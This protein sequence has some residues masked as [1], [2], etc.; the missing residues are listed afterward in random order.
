MW[1]RLQQRSHGAAASNIMATSPHWLEVLVCETASSFF[2]S[3]SSFQLQVLQFYQPTRLLQPSGPLLC[4]M[5]R[6]FDLH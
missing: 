2:L 4:R 1:R 5:L 3:F 6:L